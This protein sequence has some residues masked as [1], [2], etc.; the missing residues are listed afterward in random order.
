MGY[1]L[2]HFEGQYIR[3]G[4]GAN[5]WDRWKALLLRFEA[6]QFPI[7]NS[8]ERLLLGTGLEVT[9]GITTPQNEVVTDLIQH[10]NGEWT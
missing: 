8:C 6:T 3:G 2:N 9:D 10:N 4:N 5:N 1:D 7:F